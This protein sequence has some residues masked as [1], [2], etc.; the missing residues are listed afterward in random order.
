LPSIRY[1][2]ATFS[3]CPFLGA[4]SYG[5]TISGLQRDLDQKGSFGADKSG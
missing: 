3:T 2:S 4:D 1:F 5:N